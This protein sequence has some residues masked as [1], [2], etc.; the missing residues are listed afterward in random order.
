MFCLKFPVS[1][2]AGQAAIF[3]VRIAQ[4]LPL[5]NACVFGVYV[6]M[7]SVPYHR[8]DARQDG[9]LMVAEEYLVLPNFTGL[10]M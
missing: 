5:F 4:N 10:Q 7:A 2:V 9:I 1:D 8:Y 6:W 3:A